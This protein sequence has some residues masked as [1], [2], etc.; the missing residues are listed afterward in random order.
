[1]NDHS[2]PDKTGLQKYVP[3]REMAKCYIVQ[4]EQN[5]DG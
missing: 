3:R 2:T 1:M 5:L 4:W